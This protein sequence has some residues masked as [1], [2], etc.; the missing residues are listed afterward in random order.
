MAE[1]NENTKLTPKQ[2]RFC[3]EYT[4]D[5]NGTQ[6]AIRAGYSEK[7]AYSI[8]ER[9]LRNV[10]VKNYISQLQKKISEEL[11]IDAKYVLSGLKE[12]YERCMQH[13][14]IKDHEGNETGEYTFQ[15]NP[16][17]KALELLGKHLKLFTEQVDVT[18][19]APTFEN[20]SKIE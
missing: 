10:E 7:T 11:K 15:A 9:L 1:T 5:L 19:Y 4:I 2:K 20:E 16:A 6:A 14:A 8:A 3:E 18:T 12:I 17:N 13:E